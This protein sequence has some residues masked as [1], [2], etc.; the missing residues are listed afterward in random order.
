[1]SSRETSTPTAGA[2]VEDLR[3]EVEQL[4]ER[5]A[6]LE[7]QVGPGGSALPPAASDYRDARVLDPLDAGDTV[8]LHDLRE[9]YRS[10]TDIRD[11]STLRERIKDLVET[12]AFEQIGKQRWRY[13]GT[14]GG[15][16]D[17]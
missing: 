5:V 15:V 8:H 17:G 7:S 16:C 9:L 3:R 10:R 14:G 13:H 12:E 6:E 2:T 11:D 4:R 1:M